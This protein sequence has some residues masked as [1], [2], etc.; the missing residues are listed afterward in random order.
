[1]PRAAG[2]EIARVTFGCPGALIE[3]WNIALSWGIRSSNVGGPRLNRGMNSI[4]AALE[5]VAARLSAVIDGA[6]RSDAL[7]MSDDAAL[8]RCCGPAVR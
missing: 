8:V 5:E 1:M 7:T 3:Y 2:A 6:V 4:V